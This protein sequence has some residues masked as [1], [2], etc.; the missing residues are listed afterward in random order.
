MNNGKIT[1]RHSQPSLQDALAFGIVCPKIVFPTP[2]F[3]KFISI[4]I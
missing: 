3:S 4:I 1:L 2:I